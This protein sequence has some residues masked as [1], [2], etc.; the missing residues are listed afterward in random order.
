MK[1]S[2]RG[3]DLFV[4][5]PKGQIVEHSLSVDLRLN[6]ACCFVLTLNCKT[7]TE[8]SHLLS[9]NPSSADATSTMDRSE[10]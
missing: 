8:N 9:R 5:R 1:K 3:I 6:E 4:Q 7:D 2:L 10:K